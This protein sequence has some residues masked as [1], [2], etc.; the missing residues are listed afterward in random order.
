MTIICLTVTDLEFLAC[1]KVKF[2]WMS[3]KN[4]TRVLFIL[5]LTK[6]WVTLSIFIKLVC[7]YLISSHGKKGKNVSLPPWRAGDGEACS[8]QLFG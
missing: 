7:L 5:L 3:E 1:S 6:S 8:R 2:L 4:S